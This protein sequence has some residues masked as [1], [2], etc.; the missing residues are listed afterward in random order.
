MMFNGSVLWFR[1]VQAI[2][3]P[4]HQGRPRR[5][6]LLPPI[7]TDEIVTI[8]LSGNQKVTFGFGWVLE[9]VNSLGSPAE[10]G[11]ASEEVWGCFAFQSPILSPRSSCAAAAIAGLTS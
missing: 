4:T 1:D 8:A 5:F 7:Q 2:I 3:S 6:S 9:D 11:T 10:M